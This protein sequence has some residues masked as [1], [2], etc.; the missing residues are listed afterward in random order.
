MSA[1]R[2][3]AQTA[4]TNSSLPPGW[5]AAAAPWLCWQKWQV[6]REETYAAM[7]SRSRELRLVVRPDSKRR[8]CANSRKG[9]AVSGRKAKAALITGRLG[10]NSMCGLRK[11]PLGQLESGAVCGIGDHI[12]EDVHR[13]RFTQ[14]GQKQLHE[15]SDETRNGKQHDR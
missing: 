15:R 3:F 8:M 14:T 1:V 7:S 4:F 9:T 6:F 10:D 12:G 2:G 13:R 11:Y 5:C